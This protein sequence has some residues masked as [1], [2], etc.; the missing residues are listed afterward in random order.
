MNVEASKST[1]GVQ[2]A[3]GLLAMIV[4]A[5]AVAFAAT[6]WEANVPQESKLGLQQSTFALGILLA[7]FALSIVISASVQM[8]TL[9]S[10]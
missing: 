2:L 1:L 10:V 6:V 9:P 4:G 7:T 8:A 3:L 5:I